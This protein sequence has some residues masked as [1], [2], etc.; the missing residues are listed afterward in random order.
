MKL[1]TPPVA[2]PD[3]P[4]GTPGVSASNL[5]TPPPGVVEETVALA[6]LLIKVDI[7]SNGQIAV[8]MVKQCDY[9]LILMA[10]MN[11]L[12]ATQKIR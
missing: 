6:S 10:V 11:G 4:N 8:H 3:E 12:E 7:A 5:I 2:F 1:T 9:D